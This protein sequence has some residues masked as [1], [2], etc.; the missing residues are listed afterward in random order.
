[1]STEQA[2][3]QSLA[4]LGTIVN[5]ESVLGLPERAVLPSWFAATPRGR[6]TVPGSQ[7]VLRKH[8]SDESVVAGAWKGRRPA[9]NSC[10]PA[11]QA[12]PRVTAAQPPDPGD[13]LRRQTGTLSYRSASY[14]TMKRT[15]EFKAQVRRQPGEHLLFI[16]LCESR[17]F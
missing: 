8:A 6:G 3:T 1:M 4:P 10:P 9:P 13:A 14:E 2:S 12:G 15:N 16:S 11:P 7:W 17:I 5:I